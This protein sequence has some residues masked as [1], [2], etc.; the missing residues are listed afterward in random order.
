[1]LIQFSV[2]NHRSIKENAVISFAASKDKSLEACLLHP[3]E[4]RTL[5]PVIALYG[6]N[7]AGK[8]NVLH[9]LL[10]PC[11]TWCAAALPRSQRDRSFR[12]SLLQETGSRLPLK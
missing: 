7:A 2:E 5:L 8:S 4:K 6:A 11:R 10:T 1:M 3:D 9:A 12:G